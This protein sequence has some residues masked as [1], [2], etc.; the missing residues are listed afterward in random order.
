LAVALQERR[1]GEVLVVSPP[2]EE[3]QAHRI[4]E[5]AGGLRVLPPLGLRALFGVLSQAALYV[6][7]DGGILHA[8]VALGTPSLG[9][10]GPTEPEIWFPYE[11][12]GPYRVL[13]SCAAAE[14]GPGGELRSRLR[15]LEVGPVIDRCEALLAEGRG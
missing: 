2:G 5:E 10:F 6:G 12:L 14:A 11:K 15:D 9:L 4:A 13:H 1:R 3:E 7:N 8:A